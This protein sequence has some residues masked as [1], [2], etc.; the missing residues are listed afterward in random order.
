MKNLLFLALALLMTTVAWADDNVQPYRYK[1]DLNKV[2]NDEL[3]IELLVPNFGEDVLKFHLP[4][5]VP[6]T[7]SI[8]D[9]GRFVTT[10]EVFDKEGNSLKF[11]HPDDNTW[12]IEDAKKAHKIVYRVEDSWDTDLENVVFEPA[13]TNINDKEVFVFN[14][15]GIFGFFAGK[16]RH[17]IRIEV[18]RPENFFG[19]TALKRVGGDKDTD[20]FEASDYHLLVDSPIMFCEPDTV[21]FKVGNADIL[22]Q[23]YSP[24]GKVRSKDLVND[25]QPILE[26]QREYLGGTLPVDFYAFIIF[27]N[28]GGQNYL[29]GAAG[30]LEHSYSSFYCLFEG[31]TEAIAQTVRDVAAHEFFHIVT[32]LS[33]H[34]EEI[35]YFD[36]IDPKMSEHLW[37]YEGVTEYSAQHVQV[38]QQL[39]SIE[40]FLKQMSQKM[41]T[42]EYFKED[43][44]F[45]EMS[46]T[47]LDENKDQ[48]PNVY[49]KGALIGMCIDLKLRILSDG[50]YGI[51]ELMQDLAKKYGIEKPFKDAE[52]FDEMAKVSGF[53][54]IKEFMNT[55]VAGAKALPIQEL[56]KEAG[57]KYSTDGYAEEL[58][59]FGFDPMR[60][61]TFD[62]QKML[63]KI[64]GEDYLDDFGKELGFKEGDLIKKWDGEELNLQNV[65]SVLNQYAMKATEGYE[66]KVTVLRE[67]ELTKKEMKKRKRRE[68][69]GKSVDPIPTVEKELV[70]K[71]K[72]VKTPQ[73]HAFNVDREAGEQALK[74]RKAWLGD[75]KFEAQ[76]PKE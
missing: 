35:H 58:S 49:M 51:Q 31:E 30:A 8:Y 48:Y 22:I 26:S 45:T 67:K 16:E 33:I 39:V 3:S 15:H 27:L 46:K 61:I 23:T 62:F 7:Y 68:K 18:D 52:L 20:I 73:K 65:Q 34:S 71:L 50:K 64:V 32:P 17:P 24:T 72:V 13:G 66:L 75:Y 43:L 47:C 4:K 76:M 60:G 41:A 44:P 25:I 42:A 10:F 37:L 74:I 19:G 11:E 70:G 40:H 14:N 56:M 69:R 1:V 29:S 63:L 38:K 2:E 6:G 9:F 54:E 57:I 28:K 36:F 12:V 55:Y 53:P 59:M 21:T 5:M